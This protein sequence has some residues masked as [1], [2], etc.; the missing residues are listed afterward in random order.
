MFWDCIN[1]NQPLTTS[2]VD[3]VIGSYYVFV[4]CNISE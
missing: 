2:N 4:G 1:F 3:N